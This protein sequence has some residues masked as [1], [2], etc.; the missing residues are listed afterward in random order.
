MVDGAVPPVGALNSER[1]NLV[2]RS[3]FQSN[4]VRALQLLFAGVVGLAGGE[5]APAPAP[6][7][8]AVSGAGAG[9]AGDA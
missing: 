2:D 3:L 5:D 1:T 4:T 6:A 8:A 9:G 7:A